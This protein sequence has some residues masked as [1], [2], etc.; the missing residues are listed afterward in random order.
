MAK[1]YKLLADH[2]GMPAGTIV[3]EF[4]G[5]TYGLLRM[6][7]LASGGR[8][9]VAVIEKH[10]ELPLMAPFLST[11]LDILEEVPCQ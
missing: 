8:E 3:H 7:M 10:L 4:L 11:P 6:D 1:K 9:H 5:P 2:F